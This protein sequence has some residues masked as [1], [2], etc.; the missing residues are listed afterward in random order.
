MQVYIIYMGIILN[1]IGT[2]SYAKGLLLAYKI[3]HGSLGFI[4]NNHLTPSWG[5]AQLRTKVVI[6]NH[7]SHAD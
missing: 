3:M 2:P 4:V 1:I 6:V 5:G 7:K